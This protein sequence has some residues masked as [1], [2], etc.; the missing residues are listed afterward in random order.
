MLKVRSFVRFVWLLEQGY[1]HM[2]HTLTYLFVEKI[3]SFFLCKIDFRF[4]LV[5]MSS[6]LWQKWSSLQRSITNTSVEQWISAW[7]LSFCTQCKSSY[8][9]KS[10]ISISRRYLSKLR[11]NNGRS[12][13]PLIWHRPF[14]FGVCNCIHLNCTVRVWQF[15][16]NL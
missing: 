4:L 15:I 12:K 5:K 16:K 13:C 2:I 9:K 1:W 7:R 8:C 6:V 3:I 10:K 11:L 14:C